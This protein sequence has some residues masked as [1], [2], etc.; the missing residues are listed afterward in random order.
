MASS[1]LG[2]AATADAAALL[3]RLVAAAA[4]DSASLLNDLRTSSSWAL[5]WSASSISDKTALETSAKMMALASLR[6]LSWNRPDGTAR[7]RR[8]ELVV[9]FAGREPVSGSGIYKGC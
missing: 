5:C 4:A 7:R 1:D 2:V 6:V 3:D 9:V 8:R